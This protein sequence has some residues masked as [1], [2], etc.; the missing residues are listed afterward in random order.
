MHPATDSVRFMLRDGLPHRAS[1]ICSG[2]RISS[3][4]LEGITNHL[5][6]TECTLLIS[7]D[8]GGDL[9]Y[10]LAGGLLPWS[11]APPTSLKGNFLPELNTT[12]G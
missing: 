3:D 8:E 1:D 12:D 7:V 4:A 2:L 6:R 5:N 9:F 11:T 10:Q